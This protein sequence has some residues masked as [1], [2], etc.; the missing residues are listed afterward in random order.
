MKYLVIGCG[1]TGAP[2]GAMLTRAGKDVT[3]IARGKHYDAMKDNGLLIERL[4]NWTEE[5]VDVKTETMESYDDHPDV[6]FVCV[7]YYSLESTID[8][9]KNIVHKETIVIP[10]L[11]VYGTGGRLQESIPECRILD[12][13]IYISAEIKEPGMILMHSDIFRIV[14]GTREHEI[15]DV[16]YKIQNDLKDSGIDA[17]ISKN[18]QR[19]ALRKFSYVAPIGAC[20][21]YLGAAAGDF[22]KEG[23]A[24]D[25]FK[26]MIR[27][28]L[29]LAD[30]MGIEVKE[31]WVA[32]NMKILDALLP[33]TT[34]SMQRDVLAGRQSEMDGLVFEVLRLAE[35]YA[36]ELPVYRKVAESFRQNA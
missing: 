28:L 12:G 31:D 27:E 21:L 3:L 15:P 7:K 2:I 22:Q 33:E 1:G 17:I 13:C 20:G 4:W 6:I 36:V 35:K 14:Y 34:T 23:S 11:N 24:R 29:V 10:V 26:S 16:L 19:D 9:I 25:M 5:K 8:F 32:I 18:I 30:A